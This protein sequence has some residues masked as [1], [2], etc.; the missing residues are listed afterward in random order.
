MRSMRNWLPLAA[1]CVLLTGTLLYSY[2]SATTSDPASYFEN[3]AVVRQI[4]QL[5]AKWELDAMKSRIGLNQSYDPLTNPLPELDSLPQQLTVLA[6][7]FDPESSAA[8]TASVA[9][10]QRELGHKAILIDSFKSHYAILRNS[11]E[12][13]PV[14][15]NEISASSAIG[16]QAHSAAMARVNALAGKALLGT[17]IYDDEPSADRLTE[18]EQDLKLLAAAARILPAE[19]AHRIEL[20]SLHVQ[21]VLREHRAVDELLNDI[22]AEETGLYLDQITAVLSREQQ[23]SAMLTQRHRLYLFLLSTALA[24][25]LVYAA[26]RL[27]RSHAIINRVNKQLSQANE[28]LE[29]A[30][31]ARTGELLSANVQLQAQMAERKQL[32]GR[33]VQSENLASIGQLAAGVAHE[34]NNPLGF[35]ASNADMM[36][37]YVE[38][39]LNM[40]ALYQ[41][42]ELGMAG[43]AELAA[44]LKRRREQLELDYMRQDIPV[45]LAESRD[46]LD[47]VSKIVQSLKDFSRSDAVQQWE[48][49]DLHRCIDSTLNII[50]SE[51]R[52]VADVDKQYGA[53]PEIECMASQ[54]N[55]VIMNLLVNAAHAMGPQRGQITIRTGLEGENAWIEVQ[56]SGCGIPA[57]VLPRIF[58]PFFTTKEIGRGTGLGLSLSY[59]IVENHQGRIDVRSTPGAGSVFRVT[60]P[61]RQQRTDVAAVPA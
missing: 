5:D 32:E 12:F 53:L 41:E 2:L 14:A 25:L 16:P 50:A 18:I 40:L 36:E 54:L 9:G 17:L 37:Q 35:V 58:D 11:L 4:K 56:D 13:L 43:S 57:E 47:R 3:V 42:V 33:L 24:G 44:Q 45:L 38:R 46:G 60:L 22:G 59:G 55:Q 26:Q 34:I 28:G 10:L 6:E 21:M 48:R 19:A 1:T 23:R 49:A 30:V 51:V 7:S 29:T 39:L 15:A 31:Q 52:K 27:I 20:F 61:V 8:L